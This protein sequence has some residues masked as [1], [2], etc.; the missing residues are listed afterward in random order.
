[1]A[2]REGHRSKKRPNTKQGRVRAG[3]KYFWDT[4]FRREGKV[5][6]A[7]TLFNHARL[8]DERGGHV[9]IA[10]AADVLTLMPILFGE[11]SDA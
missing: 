2:W 10:D 7:H 11:A 3:K 5:I 9:R 4:V 6:Q 8:V 1:M